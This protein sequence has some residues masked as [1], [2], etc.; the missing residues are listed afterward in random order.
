MDTR[1]IQVPQRSRFY[2]DL[3]IIH[4]TNDSSVFLFFLLFFFSSSFTLRLCISAHRRNMERFLGISKR[5][6]L[7]ETSYPSNESKTPTTEHFY[8]NPFLI[9]FSP[10]PVFKTKKNFNDWGGGA[11]RCNLS[12][13]LSPQQ[14]ELTRRIRLYTSH[15][16]RVEFRMSRSRRF[17]R[18][19]HS[20]SR[21]GSE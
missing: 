5:E 12:P 15:L 19:F 14:R 11:I 10:P 18:H 4:S 7:F 21:Q 3:S 6:L 20:A 13:L 2:R 17:F 8:K 9:R 1:G 16:R